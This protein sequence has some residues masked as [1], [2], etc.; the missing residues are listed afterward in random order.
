[1]HIKRKTIGKFWPIPRKGTKYVAVPKH[2]KKDAISLVVIMRDILKV[3]RNKKELKRLLNNG[4]VQ[5][6]HKVIREINYPVSLFDVISL[7]EAKKNYRA[8]LSH[9]KKMVF[10]E[11]SEKESE[12]KVY[13]ILNKRLIE[14]G[15][16]QFNLMQGINLLIKEKANVGDSL[17]LNMK[18]NKVEKVIPMEKGKEAFVV[19]GKHAGNVGKIEEIIERGGKKLAKI[20]SEKGKINVWI[21]NIIVIK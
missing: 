13:K 12:N 7:P 20:S 3:V 1:M 2:N 10:E 11:V 16:T 21:K 9:Q 15:K 8:I 6:N 17:V 14:G 4:K 18:S 5:V 19:D